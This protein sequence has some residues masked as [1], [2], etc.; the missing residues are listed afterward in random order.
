MPV[1]RINDATFA[2]LSILKTWFGTK[3]PSETLDRIV[4]DAM[5]QLGLER[6]ETQEGVATNTSDGTMHFEATPGLAFT[7]PLQANIGKKVLGGPSWAS[8]LL[9]IIGE[10]KRQGLEGEMLVRE[11]GVPA[12]T[13]QYETDG[14]RHYPDLGISVQGQSASDCWREIERLS[15]KWKIPV[16]VTFEWRRS[17]KAQHPGKTGVLRSGGA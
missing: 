17:E 16:K 7:K 1:L 12:R 4:R 6:D 11:L 15:G 9:F 10:I 3:T 8:I 14:Y 2:D 5:D 13:D